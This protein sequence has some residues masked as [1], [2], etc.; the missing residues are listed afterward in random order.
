VYILDMPQVEY[1]DEFGAWWDTLT[2]NERVAV[3]AK[4]GLLEAI[5]IALGH[6]HSSQ[7]KGSKH[8]AM[9][10]LRIQIGGDPYRVLYIFDP[11]RMAYLILGGDKG[12]DDRWYEVNV[13]K[14]DKIYDRYLEELELEKLI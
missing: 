12:G 13:P 1:S 4:V 5:G 8:G 11:R 7:I 6:P 3:A 14:A 9:R 10:E 2:E